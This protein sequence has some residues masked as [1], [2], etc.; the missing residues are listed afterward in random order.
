MQ[1]N[2]GRVERLIRPSRRGKLEMLFKVRIIS[3]SNTC[4][5]QLKFWVIY[6]LSGNSFLFQTLKL[7]PCFHMIIKVLSGN[8]HYGHSPY[9]IMIFEK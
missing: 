8:I 3:F 2:A 4:I 7:L 6:C 5:R 9:L 1:D